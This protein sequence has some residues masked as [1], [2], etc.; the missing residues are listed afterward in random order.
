MFTFELQGPTPVYLGPGDLHD[1]AFKF[2]LRKL[3]L[4]E[5]RE[6]VCIHEIVIY[7]TIVLRS[8]YATEKPKQYTAIV[9]LAFIIT[10]IL[11]IVYDRLVTSHSESAVANAK[12]TSAIV[13][14]LFPANV[15]DRLF[16]H[17]PKESKMNNSGM[18]AFDNDSLVDDQAN[19]S[20]SKPIADLF[21][22]VTVMFADIAGFTAW[23]SAREPFQVFQLL[24]TIYFAL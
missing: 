16:E 7:P 24:E 18:D 15:R 8:E 4:Q 11:F 13:S 23:S 10:G 14:S 6:G 9:V 2:F 12:R 21:P 22:E 17:P 5:H 3:Q 20:K 19:R 1:P